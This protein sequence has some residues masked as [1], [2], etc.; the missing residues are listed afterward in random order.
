LRFSLESRLVYSLA[1]KHYSF[2][3]RRACIIACLVY[4]CTTA[5]QRSSKLA[6]M[7]A[8]AVIQA[9]ICLSYPAVPRE[10][11]D[12]GIYIYISKASELN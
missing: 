4:A 9:S 5:W 2:G 7:H 8:Q 10:G 11:E 1:E 3:R 12:S 6:A